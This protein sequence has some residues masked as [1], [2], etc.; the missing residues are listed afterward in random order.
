MCAKQTNRRK[1]PVPRRY[2]STTGR[3]LRASRS[4]LAPLEMVLGLPLVLLL[5][6]LM[7]NAGF[8]GMWKLRLL[9]ASRE[10]AWRSRDPRSNN[11]PDPKYQTTFWTQPE[12]PTETPLTTGTS[13]AS[14]LSIEDLGSAAAVRADVGT[15]TVDKDLLDPKRGVFQ[16]TSDVS[17][18][19]PMLPD[20]LQTLH[21]SPTH[22]ITDNC[23]PFWNTHLASNVG[24]R[25]KILYG[26]WV[27][28]PFFKRADTAFA[29]PPGQSNRGIAQIEYGSDW[30]GYE[31]AVVNTNNALFNDNLLPLG[32]FSV[33]HSNPPKYTEGRYHD[34]EVY[35]W[36]YRGLLPNPPG[37]MPSI[38][39]FIS[40][41]ASSVWDEHVEPHIMKIDDDQSLLC[42]QEDGPRETE[43][44]LPYALAGSYISFFNDA[45]GLVQDHINELNQQ[46][47]QA[48]MDLEL[49]QQAKKTT[50]IASLKTTI[51]GYQAEIK[52]ATTELE[53][54]NQILDPVIQQLQ[55]YQNDF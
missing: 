39:E 55:T 3:S 53:R 45:I 4:G 24:R 43:R 34:P 29:N 8:T 27:D 38:G 33:E 7:V 1:D 2:S 54:R 37:F 10:V 52:N 9:G 16:G 47:Q 20:S 11:L 50:A 46:L 15:L 36:I 49:A 41:D 28:N 6:A 12:H 30:Q 31:S 32:S 13:G 21:G 17:R 22:Q 26:E 14:P 48:Q 5:F 51:A 40:S 44:N 25:T 18:Q 42:E 19:F 23:F 35:Q